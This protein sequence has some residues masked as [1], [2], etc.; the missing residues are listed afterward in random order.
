MS[1]ASLSETVSLLRQID[2]APSIEQIV[3]H[4]AA[5]L[6]SFG[7][8]AIIASL[9]PGS[10]DLC[11]YNRRFLVMAKISEDWQKHYLRRQYALQDPVVSET[12]CRSSGFGWDDE[13]F[14]PKRAGRAARIMDEAAEN[15]LRRG[16]TVPV[17]TIEGAHGGM[18]FA[19]RFM[20]LAPEQRGALTLVAAYAF[21]HALLLHDHTSKPKGALSPREREALHWMAEGKTNIEIGALMRISEHGVDRHL[22]GIRAK[23]GSKNRAQAVA[24]GL[25][26]G[27]IA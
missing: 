11:R 7:V 3:S 20:D 14:L 19:G 13:D 23:L 18:T 26:H 15:G 5:Q 6:A 8:E 27:F 10:G 21:G 25:R 22:R 12:L 2:K 1:V 4:L 24:E 9:L 16:F 17:A